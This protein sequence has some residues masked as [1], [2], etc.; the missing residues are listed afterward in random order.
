MR[1]CF[2]RMRTADTRVTGAYALPKFPHIDGIPAACRSISVQDFYIR[3]I[4]RR[5]DGVT[6][7]LFG[8][9][10]APHDGRLYTPPSLWA[11][12]RSPPG[13]RCSRLKAREVI[14][15]AKKVGHSGSLPIIARFPVGHEYFTEIYSAGLPH[16]YI[17]SYTWTRGL[18]MPGARRIAFTIKSR[19]S[20]QSGCHVTAASAVEAYA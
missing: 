12:S 20:C 14:C 17:S 6:A 1:Y 13:Y 7:I 18:V 3:D 5:I 11:R 8:Y 19:S 16:D 15:Y 9:Y 2:F 10:G 4:S